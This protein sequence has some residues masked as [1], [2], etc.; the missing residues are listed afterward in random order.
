LLLDFTVF[1]GAS[2]EV[3]NVRQEYRDVV[4]HG[5]GRGLVADVAERERAALAQLRALRGASESSAVER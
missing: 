3:V 4:A 2:A 1:A 5:V